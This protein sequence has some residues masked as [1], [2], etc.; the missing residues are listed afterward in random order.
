[1]DRLR[2]AECPTYVARPH[3]S[4]II[5]FHALNDSS[6]LLAVGG[7]Y[8]DMCPSP[9][10]WPRRQGEYTST[11]WK[12][13][14]IVVGFVLGKRYM[15]SSILMPAMCYT[16]ERR[17]LNNSTHT[18][19]MGEGASIW[20]P[21]WCCH[22]I[23]HILNT[24]PGVSNVQRMKNSCM[25]CVCCVLKHTQRRHHPSPHS[26]RGC[27][28]RTA[29]NVCHNFGANIGHLCSLC[30]FISFPFR[31]LRFPSVFFF[32]SILFC[33]HSGLRWNVSL[34]PYMGDGCVCVRNVM[35]VLGVFHHRIPV[36]IDH[37]EQLSEGRSTPLFRTQGSCTYTEIQRLRN[38]I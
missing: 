36:A 32:F 12:I 27:C 35:Q 2:A 24:L 5:L 10:I 21:R 1:M 26:L 28:I 23:F 18:R 11:C 37:I 31:F 25:V 8:S 29:N 14:H 19:G 34:S 30:V 16:Q 7:V 6:R 13:N 3:Q 9:W 20:C 4:K 38:K 15:V 17:T 22:L 33:A